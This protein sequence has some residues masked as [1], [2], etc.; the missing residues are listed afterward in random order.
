MRKL[1]LIL[2]VI[3]PQGFKQWVYRHLLKWQI[4]KRVQIGFSYID[5]RQVTL[6]DDV[7]IGHFNIIRGLKCFSVGEGT[8]IANFNQMFGASYSGWASELSIG[9]HVNFMSRHFIDVGGIVIIGNHAVIGGRDTHFWSHTRALVDGKPSLEPTAVRVGDEV[10]VGARA[11][12]VSCDIPNGAVVGAGSVVTKSFPP[13]TQRLLIA[14]NPA[15]IKKRYDAAP[16]EPGINAANE[17][18]AER[19]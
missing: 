4:G 2:S 11:T 19:R 7:R 3:L 6:E 12:L 18:R 9:K 1:I 8:Y 16:A 5:A 17:D 14:G 13:E 10:Y 15:T